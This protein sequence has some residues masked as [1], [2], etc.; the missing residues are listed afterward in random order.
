MNTELIIQNLKC[1]G[2]A[3]T[4]TSK[5]GALA[6]VDNLKVDVEKS[7]VSFNYTEENDLEVVTHKLLALGYPVEGDKNSVLSKAKSFVSCATG[8]ITK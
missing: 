8:K 1:G 5:I 4:V 3:H 2:C 7:T 6:G